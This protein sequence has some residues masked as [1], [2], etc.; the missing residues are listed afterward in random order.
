M[1]RITGILAA[2]VFVTG[3]GS[4]AMAQSHMQHKSMDP[5]SMQKT[6]TDMAPAASDPASTKAFKETHMKMMKDMDITYSGNPDADFVRGMIPHHQGAIDMAKVQL[7]HGKNA[8][9]RKM[10][11]KIIKDQ[12]REIAQMQA[13]LKMNVK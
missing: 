6:K 9:I 13:W 1:N 8:Q 10:A 3:I 7:Q 5:A 11:A 2:A 12:E 4:T